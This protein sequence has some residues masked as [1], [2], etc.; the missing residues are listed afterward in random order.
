MALVN[1]GIGVDASARGGDDGIILFLRRAAA[2]AEQGASFLRRHDRQY[3]SAAMEKE[4]HPLH[5]SIPP[6]GG[7]GDTGATPSMRIGETRP[8]G[9]ARGNIGG[10][11]TGP[12]VMG[13]NGW[14]RASSI[15][16]TDR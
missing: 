11:V 3:V 2:K 13:G 16:S 14:A 15:G 1:S 9:G 12:G 7:G 8:S 4:P 5:G 6:S 10:G